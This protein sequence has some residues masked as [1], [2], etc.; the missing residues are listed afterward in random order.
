MT[1]SHGGG[2]SIHSEHEELIARFEQQWIAGESPE[3]EAFLPADR[4]RMAVLVELVT[5]EVEFRFKAGDDPRL[6]QYLLRFPELVTRKELA[7]RLAKEEFRRRR[8]RNEIV[9]IDDFALRFPAL[10]PELERELHSSVGSNSLQRELNAQVTPTSAG[11]AAT[12]SEITWLAKGGM[13]EVYVASDEALKRRV[14]MKVIQPKY[15]SNAEVLRRFVSEAEI[16]SRL[17]HPGIAPVYGVGT[18]PDGRPCYSM[19]YI[20]GESMGEAIRAFFRLGGETEK[21][22]PPSDGQSGSGSAKRSEAKRSRLDLHLP[23]RNLAFRGLL[24]RMISV[25]QT[26]AYAH[27][28]GVLHRDLKP[29]NI[30]I[31]EHGE[32]VL[33]DWGLA[34]ELD[35]RVD[36][37]KSGD[38]T[39]EQDHRDSLRTK[40]GS[41]YG[42]P[43]FMSPEQ[44][45]R[46]GKPITAA[47]DI[48]GLGATLYF[49][50]TG[51]PPFAKDS[52]SKIAERVERGEFEKPRSLCNDIPV[53][54]EAICLKAMRLEPVDRYV[55][56]SEMAVDLERYLADEAVGVLRES[57]WQSSRRWI[58]KHP[59]VVSTTVACLGLCFIGAMLATL[60]INRH[61]ITLAGKNLDLQNA[62]SVIKQEKDTALRYLSYANKGNEILG[63]VVVRIN[64]Q[65][66]KIETLGEFRQALAENLLEAVKQLETAQIGD[67]VVATTLK[68]RMAKALQEMG[69]F[70][71]A[72]A[73]FDQVRKVREKELG[74]RDPQTLDSMHDLAWA[75]ENAGNLTLALP[76]YQETLR[77]RKAELGED[78]RDTLLSMGALA[79]GYEADGKYDLALPLQEETLR[80]QR[81]KLGDDDDHTIT[82][83]GNLAHTLERVGEQER[84]IQLHEECLQ[85]TRAKKGEDHFD[86]LVAMNNLAVGYRE[87]G[88][89]EKA[90]PI[91]QAALSKLRAGVGPDNPLTLMCL[92]N[93]ARCFNQ[94][95]ELDEAHR[96]YEVVQQ[97]LQ[98]RLGIRHVSTLAATNDLAA[99]FHALKKYDQAIPLYK[100]VIDIRTELQG[101]DHPNMIVSLGNLASSYQAIG[102]YKEALALCDEAYRLSVTQFGKDHA[103]SLRTLDNLVIGLFD[104]NDIDRARGLIDEYR[105][106][107]RE[108]A[109]QMDAPF[110]TT[111]GRLVLKMLEANMYEAAEPYAR[112]CLAYR[113]VTQPDRWTLFSM[114][115][116]LGGVLLGQKKY[117]EAEPLLL[118][119]FQGME[120]RL[121]QIQPESKM[122]LTQAAK[123][124][125]E[126]YTALE[127]PV[128]IEKWQ[129]KHEELEKLFPA[130]LPKVL[131]AETKPVGGVKS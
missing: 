118:N 37:P 91:F 19:R 129:A 93:L 95:G 125:V 98:A 108:R 21:S 12:L 114:Q 38:E 131:D 2:S 66:G 60:L 100:E 13:G 92:G 20:R 121:S 120:S 79:L 83:M 130:P 101:R 22:L 5:A 14:A 107:Y 82:T 69:A 25:C 123:R 29:E 73:V 11:M 53:A 78:H 103:N 96:L 128:E 42:T 99:S 35:S 16:T 97:R 115:S 45:R 54:L 34:K 87:L 58:R 88:Q 47:A 59:V 117:A 28:Q 3:I 94:N 52:V 85:R 126:L 104:V 39:A 124:I 56:A 64:P 110:A 116:V 55:S 89:F 71:K 81:A 105:A 33:L 84:A 127:K 112:E 86:T 43:Q 77:L 4:S 74:P 122:R 49:L 24:Q 44:A 18:L 17:E 7:I 80:L 72:V 57:V 68:A 27:Q 102:K 76:L 113:Q 41:I 1:S 8:G 23:E 30:R 61:A 50:L 9:Q 70:E 90:K 67:P 46:D 106:M 40:I 26:L 36:E 109:V 48:Y 32:T 6:E 75:Y 15:E 65:G 62:N 51:R 10:A 63:S 31:G 111:L 119:G